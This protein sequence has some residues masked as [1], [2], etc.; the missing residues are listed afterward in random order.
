LFSEVQ[1]GFEPTYA[2]FANRCLTT[3]LLHPT[4]ATSDPLDG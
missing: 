1:M 4:R 3:W 2:G